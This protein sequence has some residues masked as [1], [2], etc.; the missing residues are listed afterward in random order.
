MSI[1]NKI[2]FSIFIL[3]FI[4]AYFIEP[5]RLVTK[6]LTVSTPYWNKDLSGYK[7]AVVSDLHIGSRHVDLK[8]LH[9]V[10]QELNSLDADLTV[11]LGDFDALL[12]EASQVAQDEII[13]EF[14]S[15]KSPQGSIAVL[16]NHD[17]E[18]DGV[19]KR[20]LTESNITLLENQK[21]KINYKNSSF[22]IVGFKDWWN[23]TYE[24]DE[25]IGDNTTPTIVLSH[26][27]DV[28]PLIHKPVALTLS[29]HTHGGEVRFPLIGAP[30]VPS[31]YGQK[32]AK[33]LF[34]E[35]SNTLFVTSG[36]G[37]LSRLRFLNPPEVVSITL[38]QEKE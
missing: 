32:Y 20:I 28:F 11:I 3:L 29:G 30:H 24:P 23:A 12:I 33:G 22:T 10:I 37:S 7:I 13:K 1:L 27:P 31:K 19:V 14:K 5:N 9:R 34:I 8:K 6:S 18:P 15:I 25:I 16:G 35:N 2:I 38:I 36:V 17:Y 26:N 4:T 21:H